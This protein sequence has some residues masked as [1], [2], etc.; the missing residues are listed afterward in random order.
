MAVRTSYPFQHRSRLT[1][2]PA[3]NDNGPDPTPPTVPPASGP[4]PAS[5]SLRSHRGPAAIAA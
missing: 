1:V 5:P 3:A 2:P 4:V